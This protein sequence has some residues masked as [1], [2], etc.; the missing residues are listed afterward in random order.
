MTGTLGCPDC[1]TTYSDRYYCPDCD[2]RL[3]PVH[4]PQE[5]ENPESGSV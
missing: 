2:T 4:A 5:P 3:E 1:G